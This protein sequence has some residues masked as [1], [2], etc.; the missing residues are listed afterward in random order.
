MSKDETFWSILHLT[1]ANKE[2]LLVLLD[3]KETSGKPVL[4]NHSEITLFDFQ[5]IS[6]TVIDR[7]MLEV[8]TVIKG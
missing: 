2:F 6:F 5:C 7:T 1:Q 3:K 8:K 4:F